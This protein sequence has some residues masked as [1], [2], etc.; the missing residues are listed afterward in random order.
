MPQG[1]IRVFTDTGVD[2]PTSSWS[3]G[4]DLQLLAQQVI[5]ATELVDRVF[6]LQQGLSLIGPESEV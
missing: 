5:N 6:G 1:R 3:H 2:R 4:R